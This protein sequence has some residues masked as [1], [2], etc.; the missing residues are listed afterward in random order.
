MKLEGS[1]DAF[2]LPDVFQLLSFTK[3]TGGLHL[4]NAGSDGVVF[5]GAGSITGACADSSRQPLA[6]RLVGLGAVSDEALSA[7]VTTA[8]SAHNLG[9]VRSLGQAGAVDTEVMRTVAEEQTVDAVFALTRWAGGDFAF[10]V[11]EANPDDVGVTLSISDVLAEVDARQTA[12][13][14]VAQVIPSPGTVLALAPAGSADVSV[15]REEWALVSLVD[16]RR[17]VSDIV[18]IAGAGQ[19]AVV[20]SLAAL[21]QRGLLTAGDPALDRV[22]VVQRRLLLLEPLERFVPEISQ[23]AGDA[24]PDWPTPLGVTSQEPPSTDARAVDARSEPADVP[25]PRKHDETEPADGAQNDENHDSEADAGSGVSAV[26]GA[27]DVDSTEDV[28]EAD[29]ADRAEDT[30]GD[31]VPDVGRQI[32]LLGGAHVP[33]DVVPPRPEPFLPRR[34]ADFDDEPAPAELHAVPAMA[35]VGAGISGG[36]QAVIERDASVNRSLML[37]LIAGVRGL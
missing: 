33:V 28:N 37:R 16:G 27:D 36:D 6:R 31:D 34:S 4:A 29:E 17:A 14:E 32:E 13:D 8:L 22:T 35:G 23:L 3:K 21:V 2:S 19:F 15:S 30:A 18:D 9:V 1:L 12:W 10:V 5:F 20:S 26:D 25:T 11:D 7:A 24:T